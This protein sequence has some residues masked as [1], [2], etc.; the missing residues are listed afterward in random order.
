[1]S[2]DGPLCVIT[3]PTFLPWIGW[4]DLIDHA[5]HLI[6]LDD[7]QF[8]HRSWQQ[9]NRLRASEGLR[10]LSVPVQVAGQR[11][12]RIHE[13]RLAEGPFADKA[14]AAVRSLYGKAPY[15]AARFPDFAEVLT[16][17]CAT[18]RLLTLN[19]ALIAWLA[20]QLGVGC[21]W[22]L[23]ST[24]AVGGA[25]GEHLAAL[26]A[27][28]GATRYLSTPGA[29]AYLHEDRAAFEARG[30]TVWLHRYVHPE[31]VQ[32]YP[33]FVPYAS[34]LDLVFNTGAEAGAILR[35]G[36]RPSC[37]LGAA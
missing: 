32:R 23:A 25:R 30:I 13:V 12:Q 11:T 6:L 35:S 24:L 1:M 18:G 8:A 9:R 27:H 31:Y 29:E 10:F 19:C 34:A 16:A 5:D 36:R 33:G 7:V 22:Q 28:L 15:F 2:V 37:L 3:Q 26:C 20:Q 21:S 4:F 17:A 14:L